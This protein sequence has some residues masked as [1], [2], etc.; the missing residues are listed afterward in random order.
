[1]REGYAI[2]KGKHLCSYEI[3]FRIKQHI[4]TNKHPHYVSLDLAN[5]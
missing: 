4:L 3:P 2:F 5:F 1:M